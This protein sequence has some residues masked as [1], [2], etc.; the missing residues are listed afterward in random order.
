[1]TLMFSTLMGSLVQSSSGAGEV[2]LQIE[3]SVEDLRQ[4]HVIIHSVLHNFKNV[5]LRF[6]PWST[7]LTKHMI[8]PVF[9]VYFAQ[10]LL[11]YNGVS[12]KQIAPQS[13]DYITLEAGG[14]LSGNLLIDRAYNFCEPGEYEVIYEGQLPLLNGSMLP[15]TSNRIEFSLDDGIGKCGQ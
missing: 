13:A 1:M 10:K 11:P 7:P 5:D 14:N 15:V 9:K 6:L 3:V 12:V 4:G 8:A 2:Q